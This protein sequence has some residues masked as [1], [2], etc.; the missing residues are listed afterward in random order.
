MEVLYMQE[1]FEK[2]KQ[3]WFMEVIE[4][5]GDKDYLTDYEESELKHALHILY[6]NEFFYGFDRETGVFPE[7][8]EY[9]V[10]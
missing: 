8:F 3:F 4:M 6:I 7:D 1:K 9:P 5:Y 10:F 2:K